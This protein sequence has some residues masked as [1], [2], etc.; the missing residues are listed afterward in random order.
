MIERTTSG[1]ED[2]RLFVERWE[3]INEI[4]QAMVMFS[5]VDAGAKADQVAFVD[6]RCINF[7][8]GA[9]LSVKDICDR[10]R[11]FF[12]IAVVNRNT[13]NDRFHN[14]LSP[15]TRDNIF[16]ES[17]MLTSIGVLEY[18]LPVSS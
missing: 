5:V 9:H 10:I 18:M 14:P 16:E 7:I 12:R 13:D 6:H 4:E 17:K 8:R 15:S 11:D 2:E 1:R 3:V